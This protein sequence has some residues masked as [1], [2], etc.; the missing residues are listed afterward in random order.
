M[1]NEIDELDDLIEDYNKNEKK[2]DSASNGRD[3]R[4]LTIKPA[5]K[6]YKLRL[7]PNLAA[8]QLILHSEVYEW[9]NRQGK[10]V[11]AGYSPRTFDADVSRDTIAYE[12][13]RD[14]L[15]EDGRNDIAKCLFPIPY[16]FVN[17]LVI[18]DPNE[19][20][21]NGTVRALRYKAKPRLPDYEGSGSPIH[22]AISDQIEEAGPKTIFGSGSDT[23]VLRL[24][25]KPGSV[26]YEYTPEL[27]EAGEEIDLKAL[28][29]EAIDLFE[30]VEQ[31]FT[32]EKMR[33]TIQQRLLMKR[34]RNKRFTD[35]GGDDDVTTD[36]SDDAPLAG[37]PSHSEPEEGSDSD[38]K[39]EEK[40]EAP[41]ESTDEKSDAKSD[42]KKSEPESTED[43]ASKEVSDKLD[44]LMAGM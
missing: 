44:S 8:R 39:S 18:Q 21:N 38:A 4:V 19:P 26:G 25:V 42:E 14:E 40:S 15:Y 11:W 28:Q 12:V 35:N 10:Y 24:M 43:A 36:G 30:L 34:S 9:K 32:E 2:R 3:S 41:S 22:L 16:D 1:S 7:L 5:K 37:L 29:D 27:E 13:A 20:E 23:M 17:V 33:D 31:P 6:P